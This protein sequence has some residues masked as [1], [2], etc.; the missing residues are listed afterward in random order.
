MGDLFWN[1]VAGAVIALILG[2]LAIK[3]LGH[4]LVHPHE[5]EGYAY[6]VDLSALE[7]GDTSEPEDAGPP[8]YG[9][10]LAAANIGAGERLI[11]NCTSCHSFEQGGGNGTGPALYDV[12]GRNIASVADFNYSNALNDLEGE[13]TY[14]ALDAFLTRPAA[15]AR[16][17]AMSYAGM[18][19]EEDR[20]NLIAYMR[21]LSEDP[22]PLPE[23]LAAEAPAEE[24][25]A[26]DAA[27]DET[28]MDDAAAEDAGAEDTGADDMP[29]DDAAPAEA[30]GE[31]GG[32][33]P[34]E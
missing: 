22:E 2:V 14:E 16:G 9:T 33:E 3:E 13:W 8:D 20:M 34:Q 6:P 27:M 19:S 24:A 17:T 32:D 25:P 5:S 12:V 26:E 23:P 1:K 7:G 29:A 31:E 15:Y 10:L 21:T 18:R 11:R 4:Y 30:D 28:P